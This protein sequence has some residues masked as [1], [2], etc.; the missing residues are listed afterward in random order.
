MKFAER[1]G[2]KRRTIVI[3]SINTTDD[4]NRIQH[5]IE[6]CNKVADIIILTEDDTL[7]RDIDDY[8]DLA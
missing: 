4:K 2:K 8:L 5:I 6:S 3:V 1:I 7:Q